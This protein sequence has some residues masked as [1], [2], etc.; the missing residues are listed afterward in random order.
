M[1]GCVLQVLQEWPTVI[2]DLG[3]DDVSLF[4]NYN[5]DP[6]TKIIKEVLDGNKLICTVIIQ[7]NKS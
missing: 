2:L 6:C 4:F 3:T 1:V 7:N 5:K